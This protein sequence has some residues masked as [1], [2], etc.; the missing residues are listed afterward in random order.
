M[1]AAPTARIDHPIDVPSSLDESTPTLRPRPAL[2]RGLLGVGSLLAAAA[3]LLSADPTAAEAFEP[4]LARLL[5]GMALLKASFVVAAL[6]A[7][8]W[9]LGWSIRPATAA[10]YLFSTW[11]A[12]A[13]T[14][15]IWSLD[16]LVLASLLFH[17]ALLTALVVAL[18]DGLEARSD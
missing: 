8:T 2:Y 14:T 9:R 7:L 11:T 10:L 17:L 16:R 18:R 12:A 3:G 4:D 15:M 1:S 6:A 13:A 5:Q